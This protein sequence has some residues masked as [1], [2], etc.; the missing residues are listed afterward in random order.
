MEFIVLSQFR[1]KKKLTSF[2]AFG[3]IVALSLTISMDKSNASL[4]V[5]NITQCLMENSTLPTSHA[6][7]PC[8]TINIAKKSSWSNFFTLEEKSLHFQFLN[9]IELLH[10]DFQTDK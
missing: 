8:K 1:N 9:L 4:Q 10:Y 5:N 6:Q 7:H 2:F 3:M